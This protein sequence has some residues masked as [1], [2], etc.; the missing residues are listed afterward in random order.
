MLKRVGMNK[1]ISVLCVGLLLAFPSCNDEEVVYPKIETV[2]ITPVSASNFLVKGNIISSGNSLVLEYGFVYS[3]LS[4]PDIFQ[5]TKVVVG[6]TAVTGAFE[7]NISLQTPGTTGGYTLFVRAFITNQKGTVYGA[8]KEFTVPTLIVTSV[9]PLVAKTG[10]EITINGSNFSSNEGENVVTF[11]D[12]VAE[13]IETTATQL[14]VTVPP[15]IIYPS[16]QEYYTIYVTTGGQRVDATENFRV[17]PT[18]TDFSPKTGTFGTTITITGSD[19]YPFETSLRIGGIDA[20]AAEVTQTSVTF[21]V[22]SEVTSDKLDIDLISFTDVIDVPGQFTIAVPQITSVTPLM[23]IGGTRVTITG[24]NFN[25]G[26][27]N[28]TNNVVKFGTTEATAFGTTQNEIIAFVPKGLAVGQ[29]TISV[30]TGIHTVNHNTKFTLTSPAISS[31]MPVSGIAGTYVTIT[32]TNFGIYDM[33]N[34]VLF[35]STPVDLFNWDETSI[36]VY[37]P[38]GTPSGTVKITVNASGQSVTSTADYTIL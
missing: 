37:I 24:T 35:G 12:V 31:F 25:V 4:V 34:S 15:G 21:S 36:I 23:G 13:I 3:T 27:F 10:A 7:K 22:P 33:Q 38:I 17:L 5:G 16:Y 29:Y 18:V 8:V 6:N 14:V 30:F 11:N 9:V 28:F 19:F 2:E 32:G 1:I 26:A 20:S